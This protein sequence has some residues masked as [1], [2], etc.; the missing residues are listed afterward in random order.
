M[1]EDVDADVKENFVRYHLTDDDSEITVIDDFN[2]VSKLL[3]MN[4]Y[5]FLLVKVK[6]YLSNFL[7][8]LRWNLRKSM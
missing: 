3:D 6:L 8:S 2:R 5:S 1:K 4:I 7:L